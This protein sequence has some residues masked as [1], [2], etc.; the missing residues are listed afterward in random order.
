MHYGRGGVQQSPHTNVP[1]LSPSPH[2]QQQQQQQ[3][4]QL[5]Q[6]QQQFFQQQYNSNTYSNQPTAS[7]STR[8]HRPTAS[9]PPL[10]LQSINIATASTVPRDPLTPTSAH[11]SGDLSPPDDEADDSLRISRST[12]PS[13]HHSAKCC[14]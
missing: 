11:S 3:L 9:S 5:H 2:Q 12:T 13:R 14:G 10:S 8:L 7:A 4:Q 6:L 1:V